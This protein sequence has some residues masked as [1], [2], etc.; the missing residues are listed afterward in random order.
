[1]AAEPYSGAWVHYHT[2]FHG[3]SRTGMRPDPSTDARALESGC[4]TRK[5]SSYISLPR[6]SLIYSISNFSYDRGSSG[7]T[8]NQD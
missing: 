2:V 8:Q 3:R 4:V 1:M 5:A 7:C 6:T